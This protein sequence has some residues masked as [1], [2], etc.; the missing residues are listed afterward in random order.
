M[1]HLSP[2]AVIDIAEG[3]PEPPHVAACATCR[4]A[5]ADARAVMSAVAEVE[6]P[7]PSPLFWEHFSAR[8]S[9]AVAAE[10]AHRSWR[11]SWRFAG[12]VVAL[13]AA[14]AL[15]IAVGVARRTDMPPAGAPVADS[16]ALSA[17]RNMSPLVD[18]PAEPR[19][20]LSDDGADPGLAFVADLAESADIDPA[21]VPTLGL[22]AADHAV[23]HLSDS[24]LRALAALLQADTPQERAS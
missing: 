9:E 3:A 12:G 24:E 18:R 2:E 14:A 16:A 22:S 20:L 1:R 10:R 11:A 15:V 13:A 17:P 8:V 5:V 7:Q 21:T 23:T 4:Q 6:V 19:A